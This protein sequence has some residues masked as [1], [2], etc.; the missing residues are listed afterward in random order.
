MYNPK[1]NHS[2]LILPLVLLFLLAGNPLFAGEDEFWTNRNFNPTNYTVSI[3]NNTNGL[4]HNT[5]YALEKDQFGYTWMATEEGLSRFDGTTAVV[6]EPRN[7]PELI[8]TSYYNFYPINGKGIW[9]AGDFSLVLLNKTIKQVI[10]CQSITVSSWLTALSEDENGVLWIGTKEGKIYSFHKGT[11]KPLEAWQNHTNDPIN[12][13]FIANNQLL[14][15][16]EAG[17]FV[18]HLINQTLEPIVNGP[19][20]IRHIASLGKE[21]IFGASGSGIW[22]LSPDLYIQL[23]AREKELYAINYRSIRPDEENRIWAG[24]ETGEILLIENKELKQ[25]KFPE[26]TE[27]PIRKLL[28]DGN[29]FFV[30]TQSKGLMIFRESLIQKLEHPLLSHKNIRPIFQAADESIW[31]GTRNSGVFRLKDRNTTTFDASKGMFHEG[32]LSLCG[33]EQNMFVGTREGLYRIEL[34]SNLITEDYHISQNFPRYQINTMIRDKEGKIWFSAAQGGIFYFDEN[35]KIHQVELPEHLQRTNIISSG[36]LKNGDIAFGSEGNGLLILR[37]GKLVRQIPLNLIPGENIIYAIYEDA[38][39]GIWI[40]SQGGLLLEKNGK[41]SGI[42]K[43]NGLIGNGIYSITQD[44]L[45]NIWISSNFGLQK[46]QEEELLRFKTE[47]PE[48]FFLASEIFSDKHGMSNLETNSRISPASF[49]M[50]NGQIWIPTIEGISIIDPTIFA[51]R[52]TNSIFF[53]DQLK[54]GNT[55]TNIENGLNINAGTGNF[56]I[57]FSIIDYEDDNQSSYFYRIK[58]LSEEWTYLGKRK[59]IFFSHLLPNSYT[60]EVKKLERG[61]IADIYILNF[62]ILPYFYQTLLFKILLFLTVLLLAVFFV[63]YSFK[64]KLGNQLAYKVQQRTREIEETNQ[65]LEKALKSIESQNLMLR[66][67]IWHQSHTIRGPL[68]RAM[69]VINYLKELEEHDKELS[70]EQLLEEVEKSLQELDQNIRHINQLLQEQFKE[71]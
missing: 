40:G 34:A 50:N 28:I 49:I 46:F 66:D 18:Y 16:T 4:P 26:L 22:K 1:K 45:G 71:Y 9:A 10:D 63:S 5:I 37:N 11:F 38:Q 17:L 52:K 3:W 2:L 67:T 69:A 60:L 7:S 68:T 42:R 62:R 30:G 44:K 55:F 54:I 41:F 39:G 31:I 58:E 20:K 65:L 70:H 35:K 14:I 8:E 12:S 56:S 23:I 13:L 25:I 21:V 51:E 61:K 48:D 36:I 29:H 43:E 15:G 32:I 53:W 27:N 33:D 59:E 6:F 64:V 47:D 57:T 19:K 24:T